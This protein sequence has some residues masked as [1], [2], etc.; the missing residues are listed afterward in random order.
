MRK[1]LSALLCGLAFFSGSGARAADTDGDGFSDALETALGT[2][3]ASN[4]SVPVLSGPDIPFERLGVRVQLNFDKGNG[5]VRLGGRIPLPPQGSFAMKTVVLDVGGVVKQF[6][7]DPN[8]LAVLR[9]D[10]FA[11]VPGAE[12]DGRFA[13]EFGASTAPADLADDGFD[14]TESKDKVV[15]VPVALYMEGRRFTSTL[16]GVYNAAPNKA[17]KLRANALLFSGTVDTTKLPKLPQPETTL[18]SVAPNPAKPREPVTFSAA[19]S[20]ADTDG[21]LGSIL[22][23]G[24]GGAPVRSP[25]FIFANGATQTHTYGAER[26]YTARLI[27]I[28]ANGLRQTRLFIAVGQN[29]ALNGFSGLGSTLSKNGANLQFAINTENIANNS[30]TLT[31][32]T[33]TFARDFNMPMA[34]ARS[35]GT[36]A[37]SRETVEGESVTRSTASAGITVAESTVVDENGNEQASV[38]KQVVVSDQ[39]VG[40]SDALPAPATT[41]ITVSK[42]TG[43]FLFNKSTPDQVTLKGEITLPTGFQPAKAGGNS[44]VVGIGNVVDQV[45]VDSKGKP[46]DPKTGDLGRIKRC[47]ITFPRLAKDTTATVGG[48]IAKINV[49][50]SLVDADLAGFDAEGITASLREDEQGQTEIER[51]IQ[52]GMVLEGVAFESVITV[53]FKLSANSDVGQIV[54]RSTAQ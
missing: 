24:D 19:A 38:S 15:T 54:T 40:A 42:M 6:S 12:T 21:I 2:S 45:I 37:A 46:L 31:T 28:G 30:K 11:T 50:F 48:E 41:E 44:F 17:G 18:F 4:T 36:G 8:G 29:T 22:L 23:F 10:V 47:K 16:T 52:V 7:L 9:E 39:D 33:D 13:A 32:F 5:Q 3:P 1:I 34:Q 26:G 14:A 53:E 43:K 51:Y 35:A 20:V 25:G 27:T 49:T